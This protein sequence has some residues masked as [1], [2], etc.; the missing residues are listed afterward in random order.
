MI[1]KSLVTLLSISIAAL[2]GIAGFLHAA[3]ASP[4][5]RMRE[6]GDIEGAGDAVHEMI[7]V[8]PLLIGVLFAVIPYWTVR[9][10]SDILSDA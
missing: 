9:F 2:S 10:A 7:S 6:G 4:L 8:T 3:Y 1:I 5:S